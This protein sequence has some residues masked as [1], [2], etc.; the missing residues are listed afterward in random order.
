MLWR[1][2]TREAPA[3]PTTFVREAGVKPASVNE[4]AR[5]AELV[6]STGAEVRRFGLMEGPYLER[7]SMD[8]RHVDMRRLQNGNAPVLNGHRNGKAEDVIGVVVDARIENGQ[9]VATVRF[10]E[11]AD[12]EPIWRDIVA[13]IIR[14]VSVGYQV[15]EYKESRGD[16][17]E[18]VLTATRWEPM[19]ISVVPIPADASSFIRAHGAAA[20]D[21]QDSKTDQERATAIMDLAALAGHGPDMA[22]SMIGRGLSIEDARKEL[23]HMRNQR[24]SGDPEISGHLPLD[25]YE[26][27]GATRVNWSAEDPGIR[28][29][30]MAEAMAARMMPR[31]EAPQGMARQ[32]MGRTIP[33]LCRTIMEWHGESTLGLEPAT[34]VQR[35]MAGLH[36]NGDFQAVLGEVANKTLRKGYEAAPSALKVIGRQTTA[37][38]FREKHNVMIDGSGELAELNEHG[39]IPYTTIEESDEVYKVKP[40][41]VRFGL[42]FEAMVNDDLGALQNQFRMATKWA[43]NTESA[44]LI[45]KLADNAGLG[46][47]MKADNNTLFHADHGNLA[48]AGGA[49]GVDT[50]GTARQA[51][52]KQKGLGSNDPI[53][54]T[55]KYLVV[56]AALET[57][58]E[59]VLTSIQAT[60]VADVN[61]HAGKLELVV[62]PRLDAVSA[63]AWYLAADPYAFDTIEYAYLD[64]HAAPSVEPHYLFNKLGWEFRVLL[65]FGVGVVDWR[66]MYKNPGA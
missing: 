52:R 4:E 26:A 19:E 22:R 32:Y 66:G 13:G 15:H 5:T 3:L 37:R 56:P 7:L 1:K 27:R 10:S 49:L 17:G 59:Q 9:G 58:G 25:Q 53:N 43:G 44:L 21:N 51:M 14:N 2:Q 42:S 64:G 50:L 39:E 28:R 29:T 36:T 24:I 48:G 16:K 65:F 63:T 31:E 6:W 55:P 61:P 34:L 62:D 45:A 38:D 8:P 47:T 54:V 35:T 23:L 41:G 20:P 11:R 30:A 60:K 18:A 12:V 57:T 40:Y 33:E 46:P